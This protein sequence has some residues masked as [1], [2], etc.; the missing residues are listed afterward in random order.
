M[1][2]S[3]AVVLVLAMAACTSTAD[4]DAEATEDELRLC[5]PWGTM[6]GDRTG[7]NA[8][9]APAEVAATLDWP[10][11]NVAVAA[12]GR[13]FVSFFPDTNFGPVKV[14]VVEDGHEVR[15]FPS[16]AAQ[17]E[18]HTVLGLRLDRQGRLWAVDH[19]NFGVHRPKLVAFDVAT[20]EKK[21]EIVLGLFDAPPGSMINDVV[22]AADGS[23]LYV[24]DASYVAEK[25]ALLVVDLGASPPSVRR[26]LHEHASVRRGKHDVSIDGQRV[27]FNGVFCA[28]GGVDGLALD[29]RGESLFFA[30]LNSGEVWRVPTN[31]LS[32]SAVEKYADTTMTDGMITDAK[33]NLY[34]TDMEH[35]AVVRVRPD[36]SSEVVA[37][38]A[39]LRWPDGFAW[40]PDGALY[41]T[42][43]ALHVNLPSL[44]P[45]KERVSE[46][47]PYHV[48]K[49]AVPQ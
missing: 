8:P 36:R 33:G 27:K 43:S 37:R 2:L 12:D 39:K 15:P 21:H 11:G 44:V 35:S 16:A 28:G 3:L 30:P 10:P 25:P 47:A 6:L 42:A 34:L 19:G 1:K 4:L 13:M 29:A 40:G 49:I 48:L 17:D 45:T 20:G 5:R 9:L 24:S 46:G 41:V 26:V 23:T 31:D 14:G 7:G 38:D 32:P 22:V 18:L